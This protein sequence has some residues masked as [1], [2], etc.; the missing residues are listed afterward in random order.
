MA[1][2]LPPP[3]S[4]ADLNSWKANI[5]EGLPNDREIVTVPPAT[6]FE[7]VDQ[8]SVRF[9]WDPDPQAEQYE[10]QWS[11]DPDFTRVAPESRTVTPPA[12][13]I[14]VL[15]TDRTVE[16]CDERYFFRTRSIRKGVKSA[17]SPP[18]QW[19]TPIPGDLT[20]FEALHTIDSPETENPI[21]NVNINLPRTATIG[22]SVIEDLEAL[23]TDHV[24]LFGDNWSALAAELAAGA[25]TMTVTAGTG[26]RFVVGAEYMLERG[27]EGQ[28]EIIRVV[29]VATDVITIDRAI[30]GG[31]DVTHAVAA[32]IK[33][34]AR[35]IR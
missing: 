3:R 20:L 5:E 30:W 33:W 22:G 25:P 11:R 24:E 26:I 7:A 1:L 21:I 8:R 32:E 15:L 13:T 4:R 2:R 29:S 35:I 31:N 16:S 14:T 18:S 17:W 9:R 34:F 28:Q 19:S 27:V 10:V 12:N 23:W 6:R